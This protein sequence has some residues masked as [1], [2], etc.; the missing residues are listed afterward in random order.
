MFELYSKPRV[1]IK[2]WLLSCDVM[3]YITL[4]YMHNS[5][6]L[7]LIINKSNRPLHYYAGTYA[8]CNYHN[9]SIQSLFENNNSPL[10]PPVLVVSLMSIT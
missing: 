2:C 5:L 9:I 10:P 3:N 8:A 4:H 1:C 7:R 6:M